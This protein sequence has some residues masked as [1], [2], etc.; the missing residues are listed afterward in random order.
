MKPNAPDPRALRRWLCEACGLVYDETRGDPDSGIAPGTR[1][2]DIPEDWTCP[3]CGVGKSD[4]RFIGPAPAAAAEGGD[5]GQGEMGLQAPSL[6]R[7]ADRVDTESSSS[8]RGL[9]VGRVRA[10]CATLAIRTR[11]RW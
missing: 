11:S 5:A 8:A 6:Q 1:F 2:E 4:F 9:P 10:R 7:R 3:V